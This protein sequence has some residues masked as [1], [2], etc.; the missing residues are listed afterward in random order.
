MALNKDAIL[1]HVKLQVKTS[2]NRSY[3]FNFLHIN[4]FFPNEVYKNLMEHYPHDLINKLKINKDISAVNLALSNHLEKFDEKD[5][6]FWC[7]ILK[8]VYPD[9][10]N[11]LL[12]F[13][14]KQVVEQINKLDELNIFKESKRPQFSQNKLTNSTC[15]IA[16][17]NRSENF[18]IEPHF[19]RLNEIINVLHYIPENNDN[20]DLGTQLYPVKK[21][22]VTE[23]EDLLY[24][25]VDT[26]LLGETIEIPYTPNS[27]L[28]WVN[29]S[30]TIH[31]RR[32]LPKSFERKYIFSFQLINED[33]LNM[34]AFEK[35]IDG[36]LKIRTNK[37]RL[38]YKYIPRLTS[39]FD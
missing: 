23:V 19:H 3:P 25:G 39:L 36:P 2:P 10:V 32:P 7:F 5:K 1:E 15:N 27:A 14:K 6:Q 38:F 9:I 13:L 35:K 31:G 18:A 17:Y 29:T 24:P 12:N 21:E 34:A 11:F 30:S 26:K 20:A 8:E 22:F 37:T 33:S 4:E 28:I 16:F